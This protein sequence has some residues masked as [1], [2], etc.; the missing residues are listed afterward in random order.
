MP[1]WWVMIVSIN[2]N[3]SPCSHE[4]THKI[5]W[6]MSEMTGFVIDWS[7]KN[8]CILYTPKRTK[9][10]FNSI[11]HR[12]LSN[13]QCIVKAN[14]EWWQFYKPIFFDII[15][16]NV[17]I[18]NHVYQGKTYI[19]LLLSSCMYMYFLTF[20]YLSILHFAYIFFYF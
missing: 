11:L 17:D 7:C 1:K 10:N 3:C 20:K 19:S 15:V 2:W 9:T 16:H 6:Q 8:C 4:K 13:H 5:Y 14:N 18:K 12:Y